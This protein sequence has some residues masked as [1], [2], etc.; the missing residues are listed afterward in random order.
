ML[1]IA[2]IEGITVF[3]ALLEAMSS[4]SIVRQLVGQMLFFPLVK[5]LHVLALVGIVRR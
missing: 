4:D 1:P 3:R 5:V 2:D